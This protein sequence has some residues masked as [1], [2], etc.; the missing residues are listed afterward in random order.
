M[1]TYIVYVLFFC[2]SLSGLPPDTDNSKGARHHNNHTMGDTM[3][4]VEDGMP[5]HSSNSNSNSNSSS[6]SRVEMATVTFA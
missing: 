4:E 5:L 1:L 3:V 2:V 6:S